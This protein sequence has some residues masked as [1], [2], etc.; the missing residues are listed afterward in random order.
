M[1]EE[2]QID[3]LAS[4]ARGAQATEE[5]WLL[6]DFAL[7]RSVFKLAQGAITGAVAGVLLM[8]FIK[9]RVGILNTCIGVGIG[10]Y[11]HESYSEWQNLRLFYNPEAWALGPS[12]I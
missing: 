8:P 10:F 12:D 11:A 1:N 3:S 4:L 6:A 2:I 5:Q 7:N 9:R